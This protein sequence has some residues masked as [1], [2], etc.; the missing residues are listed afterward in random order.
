VTAATLRE[1]NRRRPG[2]RDGR[3]GEQDQAERLR[4]SKGHHAGRPR[5][6]RRL[7]GNEDRG[8][9]GLCS[10]TNKILTW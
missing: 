8:D 5:L 4:T 10:T 9:R 2:V 6:D 1:Q 3:D 7:H